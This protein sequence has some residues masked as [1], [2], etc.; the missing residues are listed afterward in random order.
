MQICHSA[1]LLDVAARRNTM[2]NAQ[3]LA[4]AVRG[5]GIIVA[6][7]A[8]AAFQLRG[9]G[10]IANLTYLF[11]LNDKQAK[12]RLDQ[13]P[14][15][16]R[17]LKVLRQELHVMLQAAVGGNC[18]NALQHAAVRRL[19]KGAVSVR[20]KQPDDT[21]LAMPVATLLPNHGN[22]LQTWRDPAVATRMG[23]SAQPVHDPAEE[24]DSSKKQKFAEPSALKPQLVER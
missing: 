8:H 20:S 14:A 15:E 12:V 7:G 18:A 9:P 5:R 21:G 1:A 19:F 16:H 23:E 22:S 24:T 6:S 2:A 3:A 4:R 11:G 17:V 13:C 10:D